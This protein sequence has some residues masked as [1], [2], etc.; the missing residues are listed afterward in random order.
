MAGDH[1]SEIAGPLP[2]RVVAALPTYSRIFQ[3]R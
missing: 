1:G 2:V 3:V